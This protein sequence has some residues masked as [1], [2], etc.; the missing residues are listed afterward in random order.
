MYDIISTLN[1]FIKNNN[2][3]EIFMVEKSDVLI[4]EQYELLCN[5]AKTRAEL[6][7]VDEANFK[8]VTQWGHPIKWSK[9]DDFKIAVSEHY[10]NFV[11]AH[12][13]FDALPVNQFRKTEKGWREYLVDLKSNVSKDILL[14]NVSHTTIPKSS[15]KPEFKLIESP[16][17]TLSSA[18]PKAIPRYDSL[19]VGSRIE[20]CPESHKFISQIAQILSSAPVGA[21]LII[22]YGTT[23]IP[24]NT[25]RGIKNHKFVDPLTEPGEIDLSIDV[26][27]TDLS[28]LLEDERFATW[29]ADQGD[30]LNSMGLGYRTDQL[31][32]SCEEHND[33]ERKQK[34]IAAYKR[35]TGKNIRDMGKVYK[36]LGFV[37]DKYKS[38]QIPG[39]DSGSRKNESEAAK[40]QEDDDVAKPKPR[41]PYY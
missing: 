26:D 33:E 29:I 18:L 13:F 35:L 6:V 40:K 16:Y 34:V 36:V 38:L 8:S 4:R 25:L 41:V 24:I 9:D 27:F 11:M 21:G 37:P 31:V 23:T 10:M 39:F 12:E 5:P 14:P 32:A 3:V 28:M 20:I 15:D 30:F 2:P 22:D 19:D 1:R 7:Q 17:Q